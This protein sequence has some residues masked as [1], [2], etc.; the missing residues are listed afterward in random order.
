MAALVAGRHASSDKLCLHWLG[1]GTVGD[2][3]VQC[4]TKHQ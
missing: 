4:L 3:L 2:A 1:L